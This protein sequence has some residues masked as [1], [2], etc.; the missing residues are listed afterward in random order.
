MLTVG[1]TLNIT[2]V[3]IIIGVWTLVSCATVDGPTT[4]YDIRALDDPEV[5]ERGRYLVNG[6]AHCAA[7]HGDPALETEMRQGRE[8]PLSGGR[9]FGLGPLGTIV[10]PNITSDPVAGIGAWSDD[11]LVRSL[12]YGISR[13]GRPLIPYMSFANLSDGDLQAILS[14]LRTLAPV[15]RPAPSND[16]S[17][18][19]EVLVK[20][21]LEPEHPGPIRSYATPE[22]TAEYGR[23]LARTVANCHGCHTLRSKLTGA[24][25]GPDFAGGMEIEHA[26]VT[27][28]STNLTPLAAGTLLSFTEEQFI[29]RFRIDGRGPAGSPMPWES[30]ARMS[31]TDLGALYRYLMT[32]EPAET[33]KG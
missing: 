14:Y 1:S 11:T 26:G 7:C 6:P 20:L 33:P 12:R 18:L 27:F 19:G 16:L 13:Y 17:W 24:F 28:V 22:R 2:W 21:M 23:Y 8:I 25:I 32:L 9:A 31:D 29:E 5:I 3:V 30:F 15:A 4:S 10:A